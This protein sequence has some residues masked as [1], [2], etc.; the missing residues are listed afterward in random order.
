MARTTKPKTSPLAQKLAADREALV[1]RIA[2]LDARIEGALKAAGKKL[3]DL[4]LGRPDLENSAVAEAT[5]LQ[6]QR[7]ALETALAEV[8]QQLG[9][10]DKRWAAYEDATAAVV[11]ALEARDV[12]Q[13]ACEDL[14]DQ[15]LEKL[16]QLRG[17]N[18]EA[19]ARLSPAMR[20][21]ASTGKVGPMPTF[22]TMRWADRL[23]RIRDWP[24]IDLRLTGD[25]GNPVSRAYPDA[26]YE[27]PA[28]MG[29]IE[30]E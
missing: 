26:G 14:L 21:W 1:A 19:V 27:P 16:M 13:A 2:D 6:T 29:D 9:T 7:Q 22:R 24:L 28:E 25:L 30:L 20:G 23:R 10:A 8:D 17:A 11:T 4:P 15:L 3:A 5:S 12:V 18:R